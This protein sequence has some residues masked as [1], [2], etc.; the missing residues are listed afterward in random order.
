VL[1]ASGTSLL[2]LAA[3]LAK[4]EALDEISG[5][6]SVSRRLVLTLGALSAC[7][8]P[9]FPG[10]VALFPLSSAL[11]DRGYSSSL[12]VSAALLF[13]LGLGA[14]RLVSRAWSGEREREDAGAIGLAAVALALAA[15]LAFSIAPATLVGIAGEAALAV[16]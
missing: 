14:M 4:V 15:I 5:L 11:A 6:G 1:A 2:L 9:P 13:L 12:L 8:F 3:A 10:F 16:F 7:S